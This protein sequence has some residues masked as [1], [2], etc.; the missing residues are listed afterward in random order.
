MTSGQKDVKNLAAM[1]EKRTTITAKPRDLGPASAR[2]D[3]KPKIGK[4]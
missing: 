4:L 1:W 2:G 3:E